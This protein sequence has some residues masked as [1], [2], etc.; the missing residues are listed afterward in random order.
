MED[1]E[2]PRK[3]AVKVRGKVQNMAKKERNVKPKS[4]NFLLT[5]STN[6]RYAADS[7]DLANDSEVFDGVMQDLLN[8]IEDY[9]RL[10][11]G[12]EWSDETIKDVSIDYTIERGAR[13]GA[14]HI[15]VLLK[16]KHHT[17]VLL[18]YDKIRAKICG[19]L[20]LHNIY[21][22]NKIVKN[23]GADNILEYLDKMT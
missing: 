20:G 11:E 12:V 4:S 22:L 5:I 14:L 8:H 15:H 13:T 17:K 16:F 3:P 7:E 9:V 19:D 23:S 1:E 10:P 6:Q 18:A 21:M 2:A